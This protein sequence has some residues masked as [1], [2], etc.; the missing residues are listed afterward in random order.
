[1]DT[2]PSK[3]N[4]KPSS[5]PLPGP[6]RRGPGVRHTLIAALVGGTLVCSCGADT[7]A[8]DPAARGDVIGR[9]DV[10]GRQLH[11]ECRGT[12]NPTVVLQSGSGNAGDIWRFSE[13]HSPA[14]QHCSTRSKLHHPYRRPRDGPGPRGEPT[15]ARPTSRRDG[16]CPPRSAAPRR[17]ASPGRVH[18]WTA[19]GRTGRDPGN[20]ALHPHPA[21]RCGGRCGLPRP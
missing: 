9:V 21:A 1:M 19:S 3:P 20:H 11:L 16:G 12:D 13:S 2:N 7:Q 15:T 18:R 14:V 10:D 5:T 17:T 6:T 8:S 4:P